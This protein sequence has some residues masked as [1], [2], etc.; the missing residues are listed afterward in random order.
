MVQTPWG[1][2]PWW[3]VYLP[4]GVL[5][6]TLGSFANV[7]IYRL[8]RDESIISP[9]S[10]CPKC[11]RPI[12]P[13]ENIPVASWVALGGRCRGCRERISLR[14]PL[15]EISA[16][17]L[18]ILSFAYFGVNYAGLAH[19]IL[20][21]AL[22]A[23]VIIDLKHWLLPF[24]ITIPTTI[25]GILGVIWF[26]LHSLADSLLGMLAGLALFV[27]LMLGGKLLFK[28]EAMGG[29]DVVFGIMAGVFLGWKLTIL[30]VFVASFLGTLMAVPLLLSGRDVSGRAVPFGPFLAAATLICVFVGDDILKWYSNLIGL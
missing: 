8:P 30:M 4:V 12:R 22:L 11:G 7:L 27:A 16:A 2:L 25:I 6:L 18:T 3:L 23:L 10:R 19:S 15:V 26:D 17:G 29:G 28:R 13:W 9:P 24:A 1:P 20:F 21:V 5:G 14:Y